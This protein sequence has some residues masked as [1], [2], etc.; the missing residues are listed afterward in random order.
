[1][2]L[3]DPHGDLAEELMKKKLVASRDD[4]IILDP[5]L[6]RRG[7]ANFCI[8]PFDVYDFR[9]SSH[10]LDVYSQFLART[11]TAM[12]SDQVNLSLQMEALLIPCFR[13]LL[14]RP[15]STFFDLQ[16]FMIEDMNGDLIT[17]SQDLPDKAH[18]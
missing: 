1:M 9:L 13:V 4:L 18:R 10:D 16:R 8:N 2:V 14:D 7:K 6:D 12:L 5:L 17:L 11:F 15:G 3:I